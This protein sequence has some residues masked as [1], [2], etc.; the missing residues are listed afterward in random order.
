MNGFAT[1]MHTFGSAKYIMS[2]LNEW[3]MFPIDACSL[4]KKDTHTK[5]E[6]KHMVRD[7]DAAFRG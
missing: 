4:N 1:E 7:Q 6:I 2:L 5:N 3:N